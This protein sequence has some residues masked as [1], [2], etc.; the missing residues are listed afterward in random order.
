MITPTTRLYGAIPVDRIRTASPPRPSPH[1]RDRFLTL[2]DM[3]CAVADALDVLGIGCVVSAQAVGPLVGGA[4]ACGP[5]VTLRAVPYGGDP[6]AHRAWQAPALL[7]DRDLYGI[8]EPG[9]VAVLA[10]GGDTR[11]AVIGEL[12]AAWAG[13]AGIAGILVDG[14]VRDVEALRAQPVPV[15]SRGAI[16]SSARYRLET[17]E[18][19]G[20][21]S[22]AGA[23]VRPGD[24]IVAD[25]NG[26]AVVPAD[27]VDA[28]LTDCERA[29]AAERPLA[30]AITS[31][32]S[33]EDLI[34]RL[35][36][37]KEVR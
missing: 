23:T 30:D 16:P 9:D 28:V 11:A 27:A 10:A 4:R 2:P 12:S 19:N 13:L 32:G 3:S 18:L 8:A 33:L 22:F 34:A 1:V 24:L 17:V 14:L 31:A 37:G 21:V 36:Q 7:G 20:P 6:A 15:W 35:K 5:A 29:A 25:S 26:I